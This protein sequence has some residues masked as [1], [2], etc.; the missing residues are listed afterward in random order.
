LRILGGQP[1]DVFYLHEGD[2]D[3]DDFG[4][5][6]AVGVIDEQRVLLA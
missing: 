6:E 5:D 2:N 1:V 4:D 3:L